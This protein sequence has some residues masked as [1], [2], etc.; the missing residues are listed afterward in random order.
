MGSAQ[1]HN[2]SH[3]ETIHFTSILQRRNQYYLMMQSKSAAVMQKKMHKV[4][5]TVESVSMLKMKSKPQQLQQ[6]Q[7]LQEKKE[8]EKIHESGIMEG[9]RLITLMT[10][11]LLVIPLAGILEPKMSKVLSFFVS[12]YARGQKQKRRMPKNFAR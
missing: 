1:I 11:I 3:L 7:N 2:V 6:N 5:F 10:S 9:T 4:G 12:T 8:K